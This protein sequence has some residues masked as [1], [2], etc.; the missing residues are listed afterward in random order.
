VAHIRACVCVCVCVFSTDNI[1]VSYNR[2]ISTFTCKAIFHAEFVR[3]FTIYD[4]TKFHTSSYTAS[5][6]TVTTLK[7]V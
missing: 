7:A 4:H 1:K 2:Y 5:F 3:T 6:V